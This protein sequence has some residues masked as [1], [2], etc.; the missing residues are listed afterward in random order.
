MLCHR[1][2]GQRQWVQQ[3]RQSRAMVAF[4]SLRDLH[5]YLEM[6]QNINQR[7]PVRENL[8]KDGAMGLGRRTCL[9][10]VLSL[11]QIESEGEFHELAEQLF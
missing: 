1:G 7:P 6:P 9:T 8:E 11:V 5:A 10:L 4:S 3:L 2:H